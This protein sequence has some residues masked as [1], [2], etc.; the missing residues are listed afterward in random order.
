MNNNATAAVAMQIRIT[1][2]N[3]II[4]LLWACKYE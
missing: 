1:L 3:N 2:Y 4:I